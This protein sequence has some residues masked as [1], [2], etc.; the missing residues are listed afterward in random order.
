MLERVQHKISLEM[1]QSFSQMFT[2]EEVE[3]ALYQIGPLKASGPD[4][5]PP[6]FY[7]SFW[8]DIGPAMTSAVLECL[9]HGASIKV[10]RI[11]F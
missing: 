10:I 5:L 3:K 6:V 11:W 1:N 4:G 8:D 9:N 7:Q 2:G